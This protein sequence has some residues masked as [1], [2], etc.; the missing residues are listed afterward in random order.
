MVNIYLLL[1]ILFICDIFKFFCRP[2]ITKIAF[3]GKMFI[4][5]VIISEVRYHG[6]V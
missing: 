1:A 6:Y 2:Q 5:H 4:V 3:E